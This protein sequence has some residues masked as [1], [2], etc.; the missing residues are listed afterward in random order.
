MSYGTH[1][2]EKG[3][4]AAEGGEMGGLPWGMPCKSDTRDGVQISESFLTWYRYHA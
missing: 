1:V 4:D 2:S 3:G